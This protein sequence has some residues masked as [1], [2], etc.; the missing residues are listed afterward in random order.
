MHSFELIQALRSASYG[1]RAV[2]FTPSIDGNANFTILI[3]RNGTGK[4][5]FLGDLAR[6][7]IYL[8]SQRSKK[9]EEWRLSQDQPFRNLE[10]QVDGNAYS[11]DSSGGYIHVFRN[12]RPCEWR[13][14][15]LPSRVVALTISPFDKFPLPRYHLFL[16]SDAEA[17]NQLYAYVGSRSRGGRAGVTFLLYHALENIAQNAKWPAPGLACTRFG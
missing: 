2:G 13:D 9:Q 14:V 11:V 6:A 10:Y 7:F 5:R 3:G 16:D 17:R 8:E 15:Q 4:S 12:E 1:P